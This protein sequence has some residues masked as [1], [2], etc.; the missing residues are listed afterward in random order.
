MFTGIRR[1]QDFWS[2]RPGVDWGAAIL[3]LSAHVIYF[4]SGGHASLLHG[5][6]AS[7]RTTIYTTAASI[8]AL[9]GGFGT[10]AIAQYATA[11]GNRMV[12][13]RRFYGRRLRANWSGILSSMLI[14]SGGSLALLILDREKDPGSAVWAMEFL[15]I[16]GTLRSF[17]LVWLFRVLIGVADSDATD[18][19]RSPPVG[20]PGP[21]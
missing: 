17:R 3:V 21:P 11:S 4:R 7:Q 2:E 14:V 12:R 18:T 5:L 13:L 20:I 16:Y 15:I 6:D 8:S 1:L 9:V 19:P 10:A